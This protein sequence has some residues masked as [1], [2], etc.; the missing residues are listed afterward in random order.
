MTKFFLDANIPYSALQL[1]KQLNLEA[2][3]ARDVGLSRS[4]D[5]EIMDYAVNIKGVLVTKDLEFANIRIFP[6]RMHYGIIVLRLPPF[7]KAFQFVNVLKTFLVS[8][9]VNT[10]EKSIAIVKLGGYRLRKIE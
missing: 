5:K 9:D 2:V 3:H 4:S 1:F 10:L 8:I 7:F 6:I